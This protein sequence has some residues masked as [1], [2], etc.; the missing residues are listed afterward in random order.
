MSFLKELQRR[1][2]IRVALA[3]LAGTWLLIQVLETLVPIFGL[4]ETLARIVVLFLAIAL[5]PVLVVSWVFEWTPEGLK[6]D[7]ELEP[8]ETS[9]PQTA[10]VLD[11]A[12]MVVLALGLA[13][14]AFDKF[15]LDPGRDVEIAEKAAELARTE[16]LVGAY[17]KSIAVLPFAN[18][19]GDPQQVYLSD[20]IAEELLNLLARIPNLRVISRSSAFTFRGD[21]D[22]QD[23]VEKLNVSHVLE[24]SVRRSDDRIRVTAQLIEARTDTHI[25]SKVFERRLGEIFATQEEI[26]RLVVSELQPALLGEV[27]TARRTNEEAYTLYLQARYLKNL[28]SPEEEDQANVLVRRAL[29]LD[30]DFVPAWTLLAL[31][32]VPRGDLDLANE[33]MYKAISIDPHDALANALIGA[34]QIFGENDLED[35]VQSIGRALAKEP[36]NTEV[37]K[38]AGQIARAIG[39]FDT[40]MELLRRAVRNDPLCNRCWY[41]LAHS[42]YS[43][44]H[45]DE[46]EASIRRY[47]GLGLPELGGS[48]TLGSILLLKG[49]A[50]AALEMFDTARTDFPDWEKG[51]L[52]HRAMALYALGRQEEYELTL[53]TLVGTAGEEAPRVLAGVY[54]WTGDPD[55]AFDWLDRGLQGLDDISL[56]A[57]FPIGDPFLRPLH[58][59]PRW[60]TMWAR[61]GFR[62]ERLAAVEFRIPPDP[63]AAAATR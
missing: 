54:A 40:S 22:L 51:Y 61:V 6:R 30:R 49:D 16:A 58:D 35:G 27:P 52:A 42:Q 56:R 62:S 5:V 12:I 10:K 23:V 53:A 63:F 24:G 59:D 19:T 1:N 43:G 47:R 37:L 31:M 13:Y 34:A 9:A 17:D 8:P 21:V 60:E 41:E 20:G 57:R 15:A 33:A 18:M 50:E 38:W 46:A 44:G 14:F 7:S 39:H 11:R 29:E 26:A 25:W 48:Y 4:P 2:V 3:Y 28:G 55:A 45:L 36:N 32:S